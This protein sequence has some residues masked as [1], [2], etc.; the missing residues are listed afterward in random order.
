MPTLVN[1]TVLSNFAVVGR[2]DL[3]RSIF[4]TLY[5]TYA[6]Y[7]EIQAGLEE[8]YVFY[9]RIEVHI[10]PFRA[11]GWLRLTTIEGDD[12]LTLLE[13]LPTSLHR[14]EVSSLAIA[15]QRGW[16]FLT[17]DRAARRKADELG[18]SKSGTLGVLI[19][20]IKRGIIS[21]EEGNV[22]LHQMVAARYRSPVADLRC[23][24]PDK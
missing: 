23:L 15:K 2:L 16:R 22:L 5:L 18:V 9:S 12:E 1:T 8:G 19:R 21:L 24:L 20:A 7:D 14:G 11:D 10:H 6:V 13:S 3:L 4:D 17:D